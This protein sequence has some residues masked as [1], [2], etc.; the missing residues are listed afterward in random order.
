[1]NGV[2]IFFYKVKQLDSMLP[3]CLFSNLSQKMFTT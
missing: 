3:S 2:T 1:M